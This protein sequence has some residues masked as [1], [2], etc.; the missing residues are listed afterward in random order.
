MGECGAAGRIERDAQVNKVISVGNVRTCEVAG[1]VKDIWWTGGE[2]T[3]NKI[4]T[5]TEHDT[6]SK[7]F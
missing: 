3:L 5:K 1:K 2:Q 7:L 4:K 6:Y